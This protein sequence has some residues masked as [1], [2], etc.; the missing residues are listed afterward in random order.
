MKSKGISLL[1]ESG[2]NRESSLTI[3]QLFFLCGDFGNRSITLGLDSR[4]EGGAKIEQ[5]FHIG[6]GKRLVEVDVLPLTL[7]KGVLTRVER[8]QTRTD[9]GLLFHVA[10]G[11]FFV[12][13]HFA[14]FRRHFGNGGGDARNANRILANLGGGGGG[15]G[16]GGLGC[17]AHG[18]FAFCEVKGLSL[19]VRT[20]LPQPLDYVN[21]Y[22]QKF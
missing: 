8:I 19:V 14:L 6:L 18:F 10:S 22:F 3:S 7:A 1:L 20:T 11:G 17:L 2:R 12:E 4:C 13:P 5:G 16:G 9:F 15:G 21:R